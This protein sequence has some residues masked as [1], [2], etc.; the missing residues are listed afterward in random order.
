MK[1]YEL[2]ITRR[3]PPCGGKIPYVNE[4]KE[5][6][7]DDPVAY[8]KAHE[9]GATLEVEETEGKITVTC[10]REKEPVTYEFNEL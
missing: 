9:K 1:E 6:E 3:Q 5:I 2:L 8:V 10:V 7:T 4:I